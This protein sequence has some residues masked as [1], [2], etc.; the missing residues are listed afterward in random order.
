M[1]L[2]LEKTFSVKK[3]LYVDMDNVLVD[4]GSGIIMVPE[5]IQIEYEG[6][7]DRFLVFFR[8]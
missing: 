7:I 2:S 5:R 6:K 1:T 8:T 4:F 3:I